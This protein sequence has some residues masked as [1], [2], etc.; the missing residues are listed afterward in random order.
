M[1][2]SAVAQACVSGEVSRLDALELAA[3]DGLKIH[4][5]N[6]RAQPPVCKLMTAEQLKELKDQKREASE[7]A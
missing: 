7:V 2:H 3:K 4:V 5:V 6:A 1:I